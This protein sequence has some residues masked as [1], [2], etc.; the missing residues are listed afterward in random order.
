MLQHGARVTL[1]MHTENSLN[2]TLN[3]NGGGAKKIKYYADNQ[4]PAS[5]ILPN[6]IAEFMYDSSMDGGAGAYMLTSKPALV[7]ASGDTIRSSNTGLYYSY[8]G[9]ALKI[10]IMSYAGAAVTTAGTAAA[11]TITD[12][13][14]YTSTVGYL[15]AGTKVVAKMH[16]ANAASATIN[17]NAIGA[18]AI[19]YNGAAITADLLQANGTYTF[20]YDGTNWNV[21]QAPGVIP[22][23]PAECLDTANRCLLAYGDTDLV[24]A[25]IQGPGYIWEVVDR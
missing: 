16:L 18:K 22:L 13:T 6:T 15:N 12:A 5:Y 11:Y 8:T 19:F 3:M 21:I 7:S 10:G 14:N 1:K 17:L 25:G 23:T 20:V 4:F 9:G 2:A 24:T